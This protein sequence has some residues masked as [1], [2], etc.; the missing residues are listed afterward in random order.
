MVVWARRQ[1]V[2]FGAYSCAHLFVDGP[3]VAFDCSE[4]PDC[5]VRRIPMVNASYSCEKREAT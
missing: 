4:K 5:T 1:L 2:T 3:P